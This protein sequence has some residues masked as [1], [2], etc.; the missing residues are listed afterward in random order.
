MGGCKGGGREG[1]ENQETSV[2]IQFSEEQLDGCYNKHGS[3]SIA[4]VCSRLHEIRV[5]RSSPGALKQ[6]C[7]ILA[8]RL[9]H[10]W[11]RS[12]ETP[13]MS[14]RVHGGM[15]AVRA[16]HLHGGED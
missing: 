6:M 9:R 5:L 15:A 11:G 13:E 3:R 8:F 10:K 4:A 14:L 16:P 2:E 12:L 1:Q 7:F